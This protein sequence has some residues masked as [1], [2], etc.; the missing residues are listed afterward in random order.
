MRWTENL[1]I[2]FVTMLYGIVLSQ[3]GGM[4]VLIAATIISVAFLVGPMLINK[5]ESH[6]S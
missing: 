2:S 1:I 6:T 4:I 3:R 5:K